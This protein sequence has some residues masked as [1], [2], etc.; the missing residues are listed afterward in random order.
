MTC[1]A[2]RRSLLDGVRLILVRG[3]PWER[4]FGVGCGVEKTK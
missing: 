1:C 3:Q 4:D 2:G